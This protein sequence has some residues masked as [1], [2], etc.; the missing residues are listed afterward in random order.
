MHAVTHELVDGTPTT[1]CNQG[2]G[3]VKCIFPPRLLCGKGYL[4]CTIN[5]IAPCHERVYVILSIE[6]GVNF[7]AMSKNLQ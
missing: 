2:M 6:Q 4:H 1:F 3:F 5:I 7:C